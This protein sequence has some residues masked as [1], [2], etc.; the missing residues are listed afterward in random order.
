MG[1]QRAGDV[2]A[3][4][5]R[6]DARQAGAIRALRAPR[7]R[8]ARRPSGARAKASK[9]DAKNGQPVGTERP[10]KN[11]Q[12]S[13]VQANRKVTKRDRKSIKRTRISRTVSEQNGTKIYGSL[14]G[15]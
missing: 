1:W 11:G 13:E 9:L 6:S 12:H 8:R 7:L 14:W 5:P 4:T 3:T 10:Y 15:E 2:A